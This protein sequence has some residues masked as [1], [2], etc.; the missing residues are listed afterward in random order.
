[1]IPDS[2]AALAGQVLVA[3][4]PAGPLPEPLVGMAKR[5]ELSGFI[6]FRR[7]VTH[8]EVQLQA[9]A[10]AAQNAA[11]IAAFGSEL[12][13]LIA[14]DQEGGRVQRLRA[15]VLELPPMRALAALGDPALTQECGRVLGAQLA[16]LGFNLDFAPVLDVDSNPDN[17][18]IGD[19]SFSRDPD[20]VAEHGIAFARGLGASGVAACGKHF[21]GHGDTALDS[22]LD[23]P[24]VHHGRARLDAIELL[25]FARAHAALP[26]IMTA[27]VVFDALDPERPATLA[28]SAIAVLREQL[29][30][31]GVIVSDDL[32]MRAIADRHGIEHAAC[33]AIEAGCD[34]LL[35][36][37]DPERCQRAHAALVSRAELD[38]RFCAR[39]RDAAARCRQLRARFV[40]RPLLSDDLEARLRALSATLE[41]RLLD[42]G[43]DN[44]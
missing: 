40:P 38:E 1:M 28:P 14:V 6:L 41:Q 5:A 42:A 33:A 43:I 30:Y 23:L 18:V 44:A 4:F 20:I 15:P 9:S 31:R 13:P 16:A 8:A 7:N 39:L 27:H 10:L 25:P 32:E 12:P 11:L 17:P 35:V 21:P 19:R 24:F 37:S 2:L 36:C 34:A 22:H 3:G 29:G 26:S